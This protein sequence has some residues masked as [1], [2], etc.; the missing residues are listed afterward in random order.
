MQSYNDL[1]SG[2]FFSVCVYVNFLDEYDSGGLKIKAGTHELF[3]KK[4]GHKWRL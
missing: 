4:L 2:F 3:L 1:A